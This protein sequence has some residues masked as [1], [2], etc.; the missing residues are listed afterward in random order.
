[1]IQEFRPRVTNGIWRLIGD[2]LVLALLAT[3]AAGGWIE[4]QLIRGPGRQIAGVAAAFWVAIVAWSFLAL[5][6]AGRV[7][8]A[9]SITST[10]F[11]LGLIVWLEVGYA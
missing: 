2:Y 10:L 9:V 3:W 6:K 5:H 8:L 1:V 4:V 7:R 11:V